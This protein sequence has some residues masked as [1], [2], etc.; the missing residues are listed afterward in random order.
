MVFRQSIIA[1]GFLA[2]SGILSGPALGQDSGLYGE[3]IPA[4]AVFVRWLEGSTPLERS[5]FGYDFSDENIPANTYAAVSAELLP[6]VSIG[7]YYSVVLG[8]SGTP[9][10][11]KEPE[12]GDQT[13]VHM[14][15]VNG[16]AT[17][18]TLNIAGGG[19]EVISLTSQSEAS[20]RAVNP[21]SAS[22]EVRPEGSDLAIAQFEVALRRGQNMTFAV[23]DGDVILVP[24]AFGPVVKAE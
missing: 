17:P 12:R 3:A 2:T 5:A 24:S 11:V 22:L 1:A 4:D 21:V 7:G 15:L 9:L 10:L 19:A 14:I 18:V 16:G 20:S 8:A 6:D 13:K 23:L